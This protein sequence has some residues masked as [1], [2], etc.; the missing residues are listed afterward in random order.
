[1][2]YD[3]NMQNN[4]DHMQDSASPAHMGSKNSMP[5]TAGGDA[6]WKTPM[7]TGGGMAKE[8]NPGGA[9]PSKVGSGGSKDLGM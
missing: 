5:H 8:H 6:G 3:H 9:T 2:A 7:T 1:M 4:Y